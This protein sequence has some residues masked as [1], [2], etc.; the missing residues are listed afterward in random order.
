MSE[1]ENLAEASFLFITQAIV[2]LSTCMYTNSTHKKNP[3]LYRQYDFCLEYKTLMFKINYATR[4][5]YP[6]Q[7][8]SIYYDLLITLSVLWLLFYIF[9]IQMLMSAPV[10]HSLVILMPT[11]LTLLAVTCAIVSLDTLG[12]A[13]L[14]KVCT[15][16]E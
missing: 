16:N 11:A 14:V 6:Y 3:M 8:C 7:K 10:K 15:R 1:L 2:L 12:V 5:K 13:S 4:S 9:F